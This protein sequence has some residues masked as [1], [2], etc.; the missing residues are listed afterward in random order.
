MKKIDIRSFLIGVLGTTLTFV[1]IGADELE[2]RDGNLGDIVVNS[3]TIRDDG[4]GGFITPIIKI[5]KGPCI[6]AQ[7][8]M[9]MATSKPITNSRNLLHTLDRIEIWMEL[10]Y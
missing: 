7:V 8:K 6:W 2:N 4:H 1:L 10:L 5:K 9:K 3:I